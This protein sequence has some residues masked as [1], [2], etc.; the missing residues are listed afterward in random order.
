MTGPALLLSSR[1][2]WL[3]FGFCL[4]QA[5]AQGGVVVE[6]AGHGA[7]PDRA[8]DDELECYQNAVRRDSRFAPARYSLAHALEDPSRK[9]CVTPAAALILFFVFF[10]AVRGAW[11]V[12]QSTNGARLCAIDGR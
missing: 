11:D 8:V 3:R 1:G 6:S 12:T 5:R 4:G 7:G 9:E 2:A 10:S